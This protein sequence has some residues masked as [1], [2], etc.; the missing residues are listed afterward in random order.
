MSKSI[1]NWRTPKW[2]FDYASDRWGPFDVDA[3]ARQEDTLCKR[4]ISSEHTE[5]QRS[6]ILSD[7][8]Y[9][10]CNPPFKL[11][12]K[13]V[14]DIVDHVYTTTSKPHTASVA[15]L[16]L[17]ASLETKWFHMYHRYATTYVIHPRIKFDLPE[18]PRD[19]KDN[20]IE[21]CVRGNDSPR[22][23]TMFMLFGYYFERG[24]INICNL[25]KN[26]K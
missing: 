24:Q 3:A 25:S 21:T 14:R 12:R 9:I 4:F 22:G 19:E 15:C 17:P 5:E 18:E 6:E 7:S 23:A 11:A 2:L 13:F 20:L 8:L 16:L 10:W 1:Q 26:T